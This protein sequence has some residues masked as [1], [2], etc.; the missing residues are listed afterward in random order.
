MFGIF[1]KVDSR[2]ISQYLGSL[3]VDYYGIRGVEYRS[4]VI[5][6]DGI[7][8]NNET[9]LAG[10]ERRDMV[11]RDSWDWKEKLIC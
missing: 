1:S 4:E 8:K 3:L 9:C 6:E 11:W 10:L 7:N 5:E 2:S